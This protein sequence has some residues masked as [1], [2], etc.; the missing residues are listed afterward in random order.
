MLAI[1]FIHFDGKPSE[2]ESSLVDFHFVTFERLQHLKS[3]IPSH[4]HAT[5]L[6]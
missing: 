3:Q 4:N 5:D 2:I 1:K 6:V